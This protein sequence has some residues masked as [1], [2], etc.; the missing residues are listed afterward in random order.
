MKIYRF[1]ICLLLVSTGL[2][3]Q[4]SILENFRILRANDPVPESIHQLLNDNLQESISEFSYEEKLR[5]FEVQQMLQEG[6]ILFNDEISSYLNQLGKIIK[7]KDSNFDDSI[8]FMVL[9][10]DIPVIIKSPTNLVLLSTGLLSR[11]E[12]EAQLIFLMA[13][14]SQQQL[15]PYEQV[16]EDISFYKDYVRENINDFSSIT[17]K[18]ILNIINNK[19]LETDVKEN[20][21][22]VKTLQKLG[23][24]G[25]EASSALKIF[26]KSK[27]PF[28]EETPDFYTQL[29]NSYPFSIPEDYMM[30]NEVKTVNI[31]NQSHYSNIKQ[32]IKLLKRQENAAGTSADL[33]LLDKQTFHQAVA[34]AKFSVINEEIAHFDYIRAL[35]HTLLL[36]KEFENNKFLDFSMAR[37][38]YGL[39]NQK[40]AK[41]WAKFKSNYKKLPGSIS[42][43]TDILSN[44]NKEELNLL[45]LGHIHALVKKYPEDEIFQEYYA[46]TKQD[47][48]DYT[49][50][51]LDN[52]LKKEALEE[53]E[54]INVEKI[55]KIDEESLT[56][57]ERVKAKKKNRLN[58]APKPVSSNNDRS[59]LYAH[60][61][62]LAFNELKF[63]FNG[64][65]S[66]KKYRESELPT[67]R[68]RNG[69]YQ[70]PD[71]GFSE[72]I[73]TSPSLFMFNKKTGKIDVEKSMDRSK[74]MLD[75]MNNELKE[76]DELILHKKE[77]TFTALEYNNQAL[78]EQSIS[79]INFIH[80]D[81]N[82]ILSNKDLLDVYLT[83]TMNPF[84][85]K[86]TVVRFNKVMRIGNEYD[87]FRFSSFLP[88]S[89]LKGLFFD[90]FGE[91]SKLLIYNHI[92]D[93]E[94]GTCT[95]EY[96]KEVR[97]TGSPS[98][99]NNEILKMLKILKLQ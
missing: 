38:M 32:Q 13:K 35:I 50:L 48:R 66:D 84:I 64:G 65:A 19:S 54:K 69:N 24:P 37:I 77:R 74:H 92:Y 78:L 7:E 6:K 44:L 85:S 95:Y 8:D 15:S 56:K 17:D 53:L 28:S 75:L 40:N 72:L 57:A 93:L 31:K 51:S 45:A 2:M 11:V 52:F 70:N 73:F 26:I 96:F 58:Q 34:L 1:I 81:F 76:E 63:V 89:I 71:G 59:L 79:E 83:E 47:V 61:D 25:Q 46:Q 30:A 60:F 87:S 5:L 29:F 39:E 42:I 9:K 41:N 90:P 33:F 99:I 14:G 67:I 27:L 82:M 49:S 68:L 80:D 16:E 3:G 86:C 91:R 23:F 4:N 18:V 88:S 94:E 10:S 62:T 55:K 98:S 20:K 36:K 22:A 97:A 12:N 43:L 21:K